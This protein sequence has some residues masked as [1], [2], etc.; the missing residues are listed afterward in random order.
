V[1]ECVG[2][3]RMGIETDFYY[4]SMYTVQLHHCF[5]VRTRQS[6]KETVRLSASR[7]R[8]HRYTQLACL[9]VVYFE[10]L[11]TDNTPPHF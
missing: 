5:K 3:I 2:R 9:Y 4:R 11:V 7:P 1:D 8:K 6:V 10:K